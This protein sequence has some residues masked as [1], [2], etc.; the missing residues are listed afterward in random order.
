[1]DVRDELITKEDT[2]E[3]EPMNCQRCSGLMVSEYEPRHYDG[4]GEYEP[5]ATAMRRCVTCGNYED[6]VILLNRQGPHYRRD[7][8]G[9]KGTYTRRA[10]ARRKHHQR[11]SWVWA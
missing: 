3:D 8:N 7:D 9:K 4:S 10:V 2:M 5:Q 6:Q 11:E 1:M